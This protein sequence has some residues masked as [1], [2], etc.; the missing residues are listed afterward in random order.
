VRH[1]GRFAPVVKCDAESLYPSIMLAEQIAPVSDRLDIFIPMLSILTERRLHAKRDER[2]ASG[3]RRGQLRGIQSSLKV[4]IN[5]FYGYLGY[6]RGYFNDYDAAE[7][8]TLRGQEIV[9]R[10]VDELER[11]GAVAIEVDTDGVFF[12][13]PASVSSEDEEMALVDAVSA[14]LGAGIRLAHDGRFRGM[15]SLKLKNYALLDFDGRVYLKGSSLRSRRE[16]LFLRRFV[17]DAVARLLEPDRHGS[18]RDYYLDVA[19]SILQGRLAPEEISRTETITDQT[20]R[21]ESNRRLAEA[22]VGERV[23]E[24]ILVYQRADGTIARTTTYAGDED[25]AYLLKR[26][27][28][29]AE[30]FRP[31]YSGDGEFDYTFPS[32]TPRTDTTALRN[33]QMVSQLSLFPP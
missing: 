7:R 9:R 6:S 20:F 15:L 12:Q 26:L 24:R 28:D 23:G 33:S 31:L 29:M 10:I 3:K 14:R 1:V 13:P 8:I 11:R 2:T 18:V 27:R 32:I 21:S 19:D 25:R 30:R 16:E 22:V 17:T 5:S 4:L